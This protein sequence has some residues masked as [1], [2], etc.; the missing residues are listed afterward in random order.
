MIEE[1]NIEEVVAFTI[2]SSDIAS[3]KVGSQFYP[4]NVVKEGAIGT[5]SK[6]RTEYLFR[7]INLRTLLGDLY[8]KYDYFNLELTSIV[9]IGN[10]GGAVLNGNVNK[11]YRSLSVFIEGFDWVNSGFNQKTGNNRSKAYLTCV[12]NNDDEWITNASGLQIYSN[13][14]ELTNLYFKK[15]PSVNIKIN[16]GSLV[17]EVIPDF[18]ILSTLVHPHTAFRFNIYPVK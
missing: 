11:E 3:N 13:S 4:Y 12:A 16:M 1:Y 8:D 9:L 17:Q 5:I 7:N 2:K 15:E 10:S 14:Y 6:Y 18:L